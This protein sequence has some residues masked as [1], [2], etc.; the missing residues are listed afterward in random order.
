MQQR[1]IGKLEKVERG[2]KGSVYKHSCFA[3]ISHHIVEILN[4]LSLNCK[5][6]TSV[7][8]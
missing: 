1:G 5:C 6:N 4:H 8:F 3:R 7:T 2:G